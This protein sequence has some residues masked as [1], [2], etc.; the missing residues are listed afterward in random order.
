M[1]F[2]SR[3]CGDILSLFMEEEM[4]ENK[5]QPIFSLISCMCL[6]LVLGIIYLW[7]IFKDPVVEY[8]SWTSAASSRV[9]SIMLP[10]N[11]CGIMFG[12]FLNDK[13]GPRLVLTVGAC[14][15]ICGMSLTSLIPVG[16]PWAIYIT[17]AV[18]V[19]L[20]A[21]LINNTCLSVV[22][23]WWYWKRG[24]AVGLTNGA[25]ALS[26]VVFAPLINQMLK[27]RLNVSG[28][29]RVFAVIFLL[30]ILTVGRNVHLPP[31]GWV[32]PVK[33]EKGQTNFTGHQYQPK[34]VLHSAKYYLLLCCIVC[35]TC[36][37]LMLNT[38]FKSY[39]LHKGLTETMAVTCV[40]LTGVASAAGRLLV[41]W[42]SDKMSSIKIMSGLY[43]IIFCSMGALFFAE[44]W[45]YTLCISGICFCY[46][47]S[48]SMTSVMN[49]ESFGSQYL[50]SN[51][52]LMAVAVLFSGIVYP[53]LGTALSLDG[54]PSVAMLIV[55]MVLSIVGLIAINILGKVNRRDYA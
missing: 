41:A 8:F 20:G 37:Y 34:D 46:G 29:F 17:Y 50:S 7:S 44:G 48:A 43:I 5:G 9:F 22:Q 23:K 51:Y 36:A 16:S 39:A 30:L 13:K 42:L 1:R 55:P 40:M 25:Y 10:T 3:D 11:V 45:G 53:S 4:K 32:K 12:G 52:G 38:I 14:L 24:L 18:M 35:V 33:Q 47:A 54:I 2:G 27:S 19:G 15:V 31:V 49:V 28:T 26:S 6:M 21:G